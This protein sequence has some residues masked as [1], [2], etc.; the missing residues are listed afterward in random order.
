MQN[1]QIELKIKPRKEITCYFCI[2]VRLSVFSANFS[3]G[4]SAGS[5][6]VIFFFFFFLVGSKGT[7]CDLE[8]QVSGDGMLQQTEISTKLNNRNM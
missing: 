6:I 8:I 2:P 4:S 5:T 1:S 7:I 3:T